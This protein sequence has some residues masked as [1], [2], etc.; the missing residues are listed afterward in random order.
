MGL[1]FQIRDD[2]LDVTSTEEELGK[3]IGSDERNLKTTWV[4]TYGLEQAEKDVEKYTEEAAA[5]LASLPGDPG[6]LTEW[7]RKIGKRK[8]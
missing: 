8:N 2:I 6:P 7:V 1:A 3:P 4:T 5:L